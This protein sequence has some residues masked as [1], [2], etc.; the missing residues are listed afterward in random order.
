MEKILKFPNNLIQF[1][2]EAYAELKK[3]TWLSKKDVMRATLGVIIVVIIFA[4]YVGLI[5]FLISR[6]FA[7]FIGR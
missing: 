5:D 1:I 2:K 6:L 7:L 4:I 3:V